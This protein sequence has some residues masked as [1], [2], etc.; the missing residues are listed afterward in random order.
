MNNQVSG[1]DHPHYYFFIRG[2]I[3]SRFHWHEFPGTFQQLLDQKANQTSSAST[4]VFIDI[5][6][7]GERFQQSTPFSIAHIAED[8][9]QQIKA[10]LHSNKVSE[11]SKLHLVGISMGG[12]IA[13]ELIS[14]IQSMKS[15]NDKAALNFTSLHIINSSFANLSPFWQRMRLPAI[16]N[17]LPKLWQTK[18]REAGILHWTSNRQE[19]S[20]LVNAWV[21]EANKHP[22]AL[23]NAFAQ[24]W[25]A[26]HYFV[27]QNPSINS[28]IY[29]SQQDRL[30][31]W[32]CSAKL[33]HYWG[34]PL[35]THATAGHDLP[36]DSPDWLAQQIT[37][38]SQNHD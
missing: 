38:N 1:R 2:L 10:Y 21:E 20:R 24:L 8:T 9:Q 36:L 16:L 5:P 4:L 3:R 32:R 11:K 33:A 12:M 26:S 14:Q 22:L 31:D 15:K 34:R 30:V 35:Y 37:N 17:L 7:N 6:G 23:R 29:S 13:A 19:S 28:Y 25:A 18:S 27:S